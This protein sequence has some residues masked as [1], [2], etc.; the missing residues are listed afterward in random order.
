MGRRWVLGLIA[1]LVLLLAGLTAWGT[2]SPVGEL[3]VLNLLGRRAAYITDADGRVVAILPR[4]L[5]HHTTPVDRSGQLDNLDGLL[6]MLAALAATGN[7]DDLHTA[8]DLVP[9]AGPEPGTVRVT[10]TV[11]TEHLEAVA[12]TLGDRGHCHAG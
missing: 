7:P 4:N 6:D 3:V 9:L 5:P 11:P 10:V 1:G 8:L 12:R 2:Q